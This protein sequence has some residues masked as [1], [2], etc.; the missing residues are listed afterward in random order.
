MSDLDQEQITAQ[1][2][3]EEIT[4]QGTLRPEGTPLVIDIKPRV[5]PAADLDQI[6]L[7]DETAKGVAR[8]MELPL[9]LNTNEHGAV[10]YTPQFPDIDPV[11]IENQQPIKEEVGLVEDIGRGLAMFAKGAENMNALMPIPEGMMSF[12][13]GRPVTNLAEVVEVLGGMFDQATGLN[14]SER[15]PDPV[16]ITGG[17]VGGV[18]QALPGMIPAIKLAKVAGMGPVLAD[19]VGGFVGDMATSSEVEAEKLVKLFGSVASKEGAAA[20][21]EFMKDENGDIDE[22]KARLIAGVPGLIAGPAIHGVVKLASMARKSS[23]G[24]AL[25]K[26]FVKMMADESGEVKLPGMGAGGRVKMGQDMQPTGKA[27]TPDELTAARAETVKDGVTVAQRLDTIIPQAERVDGGVFRHG[28]PNGKEWSTLTPKELAKR[29]PGATFKDT[30]LDR[31]WNE[32]LA[33]VSAAARDAVERTG[34]TWTAFKA[35]DWDKALRLPLRSQLWYE[36]SGE[37]FAKLLP[38]LTHNEFMMFVDLIGATSARA[39]PLENLQRSLAVLS[40]RKRG[41]PVDV[42]LTIQKSVEDALM[43]NGTEI[44]SALG[45]KTGMFSDTLAMVGGVQTRYPISVNDVWV[46]DMFGIDGKLMTANQSLHEVFGKYMNKLRDLTNVGAKKG[47]VRHQSWQ[48]QARGWVQARSAAD[49][50]DTS[51]A[52]SDIDGSD[53]AG[54]WSKIVAMLEDAGIS[55]PGGKITDKILMDPRVADALR[56]TTPAFRSAPKATVEFGTLLTANG[57][58]AHKAYS[59]AVES[60][61]AKTVEEYEGALASALYNSGQGATAWEKAVRVATNS[62]DKV[63]RINTASGADPFAFSGTFE[64]AVGANIRIPLKDMTP[65]QIAYFNAVAG[66]G[67]KQKAMAAAEIH[68]IGKTDPLPAGA[69][70]TASV[71]FDHSGAVPKDM[72][73]DFA[74]A[75]GAGFEVSAAKHPGSLVFDINPKFDDAGNA[76][77]PTAAELDAAVDIMAKKHNIKNAKAFRAAFKSEYGKNYVEDPGDQTAYNAIID[78]TLREWTTDV[79]QQVKAI[80]GDSVTDKQ[81]EVWLNGATSKLPVTKSKL[82]DGVEISSVRGRASTVR[83]RFRQ[84]LSDHASVEKAFDDIGKGVDAKF[85][86]LLPKWQKRADALA[87]KQGSTAPKGGSE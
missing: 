59:Q 21:T 74:D 46:G 31:I 49:G 18:A 23:G 22:L 34:A 10:Y 44:S 43:R 36:L 56:P 87:K 78:A 51:K 11:G 20:L 68:R 3:P 37:Q 33:E 76:V 48:L 72:I 80:T 8:G 85:E 17:L 84:R 55:V 69:I 9:Q 66:K 64:G 73:G 52:A 28:M 2:A 61:N 58:A 39:K 30:D 82:P 19:I 67:L 13:D 35:N 29:G 63:T 57:R 6:L 70:E 79:R 16:G 60:G 15:I 45:N 27:P 25:I 12:P 65:D 1:T 81:I 54:E 50:I 42:D 77:G 32:T 83:K 14:T 5:D 38:D 7:E 62:S 47:D 75:L 40:Q 4:P 26:Q 71:M 41:V 53:Y 86:K 24:Q